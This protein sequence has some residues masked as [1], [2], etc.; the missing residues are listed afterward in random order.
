[1][2]TQAEKRATSL[3][4]WRS[5][6]RWTLV[7]IRPP[8]VLKCSWSKSVFMAA[9]GLDSWGQQHPRMNLAGTEQI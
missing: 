7:L 3:G 9:D 2:A 8:R 5:Q 6:R 4:A 1:M